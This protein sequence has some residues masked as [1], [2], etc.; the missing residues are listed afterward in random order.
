M[1]SVVLISGLEGLVQMYYKN[2]TMNLT[3]LKCKI[4]FLFSISVLFQ[5]NRVKGFI[6]LFFDRLF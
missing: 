1:I 5:H 3:L 6:I 4:I 2:R